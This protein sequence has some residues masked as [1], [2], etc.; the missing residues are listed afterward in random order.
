M[1]EC[2]GW[3]VMKKTEGRKPYPLRIP[4]PTGTPKRMVWRTKN[5]RNMDQHDT[6]DEDNAGE[7]DC[8][9]YIIGAH[10]SKGSTKSGQ[11]S[12]SA[13]TKDK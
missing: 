11:A 10:G 5:G 3:Q 13:H 2:G 9:E 6:R 8:I 12:W 1:S 4:D 7:K